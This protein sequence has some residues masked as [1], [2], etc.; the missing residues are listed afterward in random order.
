VKVEPLAEDDMKRVWGNISKRCDEEVYVRTRGITL[1]G[2][3]I[4]DTE[5]DLF[6]GRR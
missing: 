4:K 2:F 1:A 6:P 5:E 3:D